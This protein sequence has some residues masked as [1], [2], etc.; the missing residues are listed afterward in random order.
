MFFGPPA[1]R[2]KGSLREIREKFELE[3]RDLLVRS[4]KLLLERRSLAR[5]AKSFSTP[6]CPEAS[7]RR[8][9]VENSENNARLPF[10]FLPDENIII[11][12]TE[13]KNIVM[14]L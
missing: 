11:A 5:N 8:S 4:I 1:K 2:E 12:K 7:C 6:H 9:K 10:P 14:Q 13:K 3:T